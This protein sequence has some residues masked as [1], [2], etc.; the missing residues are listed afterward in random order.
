MHRLWESESRVAQKR[1]DA[2]A[3]DE[4]K[5]R[6]HAVG[7]SHCPR[8]HETAHRRHSKAL[9][10]IFDVL[11]FTAQ[12]VI[13]NSK[14]KSTQRHS[15]QRDTGRKSDFHAMNDRLRVSE[16]VAAAPSEKVVRFDDSSSGDIVAV[17]DSVQDDLVTAAA[18]EPAPADHLSALQSD[19][20]NSP[21]Q[22][23]TQ[24]DTQ[25]SSTETN[26]LLNLQTASAS[27]LEPKELAFGINYV[28]GI[29]SKH[30]SVVDKE[31]FV[32]EALHCMFSGLIPPIGAALLHPER[33]RTDNR[34]TEE[35]EMLQCTNTPT[36]KASK[37]T[38]AL[39]EERY[40][41]RRVGIQSI[42]DS[43]IS[44]KYFLVV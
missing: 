4:D 7:M 35:R 21:S 42:E 25:T 38:N 3:K 32:Q 34:T 36:L 17:A 13:D 24:N 11:R 19:N 37:V 18:N 23:P 41:L 6:Q 5:R 39:V 2:L 29:L 26:S 22:T 44:C 9:G 27:F 12:L 28:L 8:N 30:S 16:L 40:R 31:T 14:A 33:R 20:D 1:K 43:L 10:E 15:P